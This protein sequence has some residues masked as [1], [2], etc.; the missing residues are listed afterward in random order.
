MY[1][2]ALDKLM[3]SIKNA[4]S[5]PLISVC[6]I[7]NKYRDPI[8]ATRRVHGNTPYYGANGIIDYV[9]GFTHDGNFIILAE[10]GTISVQPYSVLRAYGKFWA[11]NNIQYNKTKR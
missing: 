6:D 5:L 4:D 10:A 3:D 1:W 7:F 9:D 2:G 11:N 8:A